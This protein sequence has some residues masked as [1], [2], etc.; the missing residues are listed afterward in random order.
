MT[1]LALCVATLAAAL[2]PALAAPPPPLDKNT[3]EQL[4]ESLTALKFKNKAPTEIPAKMKRSG[5]GED[6]LSS[7][8]AA[9]HL[10]KYILDTGDMDGVMEFLQHMVRAGKMSDKEGITYVN[11]LVDHLQT[12]LKEAPSPTKEAEGRRGQHEE[13]LR[14]ISRE[15]E[16]LARSK[17]AIEDRIKDLETKK[18]KEEEIVKGQQ[19]A[20]FAE[21]EG[22]NDN[23]TILNINQII[24]DQRSKNLISKTLYLHVKEALIETAVENLAAL[25]E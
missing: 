6:D 13:L 21:E 20:T 19:L 7:G 23:E 10:A 24:E 18:T 8:G 22:E 5:L 14:S 12:K 15:Q 11:S 17:Q 2:A 3:K 9:S 16:T 4:T 1:P 25:A